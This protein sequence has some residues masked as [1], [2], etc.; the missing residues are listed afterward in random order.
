M[1]GFWL[2]VAVVLSILA[3]GAA[4]VVLGAAAK[5]WPGTVGNIVASV[6]SSRAWPRWRHREGSAAIAVDMAWLA[7]CCAIAMVGYLLTRSDG[8]PQVAGV[9]LLVGAASGAFFVLSMLINRPE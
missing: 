3:I 4:S 5:R 7:A 6:G 9:F 2:F 8:F 1:N